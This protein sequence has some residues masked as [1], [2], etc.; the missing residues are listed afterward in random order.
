LGGV[1]VVAGVAA[2]VL[3]VADAELLGLRPVLA[4]LGGVL[5]AAAGAVLAARG[6]RLRRLG[7]R[8]ESPA[9]K[10]ATEDPD[11]DLWQALSDG[12]DP[13]AGG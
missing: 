12:R 3:A 1:L 8:Y 6:H 11:D 2:C 10:R 7:A 5:V 4:L 13:T 9:A